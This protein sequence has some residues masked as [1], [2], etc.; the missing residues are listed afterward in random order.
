MARLVN[1]ESLVEEAL[2]RV[3]REEYVREIGAQYWP[4]LHVQSQ[5]LHVDI[6]GFKFHHSHAGPA[7]HE[8][9]E[10][11]PI[12]WMLELNASLPDRGLRSNPLASEADSFVHIIRNIAD[13]NLGGE[14]S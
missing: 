1:A 9:Q 11:M 12:N 10:D 8:A 7:A 4:I 6:Y 14:Y 13:P 5:I 2:L 3:F